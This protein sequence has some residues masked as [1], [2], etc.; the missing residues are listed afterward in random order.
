MG[1]KLIAIRGATTIESDSAEQIAQKSTELVRLIVDRNNLKPNDIISIT[2]SSTA[3]ITAS[4]PA[5]AIRESDILGDT[6]L[7]SCLEPSIKGALPL[8]I[9]V[10][11]MCQ[12]K[13]APNHIYLHGA[14]IL[15][16]DIKENR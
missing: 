6:P 8:C 5:K 15:R 9:R 16:P 12:S 2:I 10:M 7:F 13:S 4:Y 1:K 3:D 11:I 14:K